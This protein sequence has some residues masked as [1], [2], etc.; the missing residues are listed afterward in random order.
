MPRGFDPQT[1]QSTGIAYS[2]EV[3]SAAPA[4]QLAQLL[5]LV[6]Q[7]AEI[8]SAITIADDMAKNFRIEP[9]N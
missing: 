5:D 4:G 2:V 3:S 6:D 9:A 7:V 1:W 8:P